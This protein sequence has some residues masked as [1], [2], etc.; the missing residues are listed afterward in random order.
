MEHTSS[1]KNIASFHAI[2]FT[3]KNE[4]QTGLFKKYL[5][6]C[7]LQDENRF[8]WL[9]ISLVGSIG[10]VLPVT[11]FSILS[12]GNNFNLWIVACA[13]NVLVLALNLAAQPPRV[14]IHFLFFAWLVDLSMIAY[15]AAWI[16][17]K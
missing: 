6:W 8:V 13:V 3:E 15:C 11:L 4:R 7:S 16:F 14:T 2:S 9:A 1:L 12:A 17:I 5:N 10:M